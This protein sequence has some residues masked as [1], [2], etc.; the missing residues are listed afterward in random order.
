M[1]LFFCLGVCRKVKPS[2]GKRGHSHNDGDATM[3]T[4]NTV[5]VTKSIQSF[6]V[7]SKL[8]KEALVTQVSF[9]I[10]V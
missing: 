1:L 5:L 3:G 4:V 6:E 2:Y 10:L 7:F 8:V 9:I